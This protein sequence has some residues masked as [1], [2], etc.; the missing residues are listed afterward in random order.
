MR[1]SAIVPLAIAL[2]CGLI[3]AVGVSQVVLNSDSG[4]AE[5]K[6]VEIFV[7]VNDLD[8]GNKVT[9]DVVKLERWPAD[10]VPKGALNDLAKVEGKYARQRMFAGEPLMERKLMDSSN[11]IDDLIPEGYR[12]VTLSIKNDQGVA[13]LIEPGYR[14]DVNGFF[15]KSS[16]VPEVTTKTVL[17]NVRVFAVDGRTSRRDPDDDTP[18]RPAQVVSLLIRE[19]D[20]EVWT[21]AGEEGVLKLSIRNHSAGS[22]ENT[23]GPNPAGQA[24]MAWIK[25]TSRAAQQKED[26]EAAAAAASTAAALPV[27]LVEEKDEWEM[28]VL[29]PT[30]PRVYVWRPGSSVPEL[31]GAAAAAAA[32]PATDRA[33]LE[34][35]SS[36]FYEPEATPPTTPPTDSQQVVPG[37]TP[38]PA[39]DQRAGN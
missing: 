36:P 39:A 23:Q 21:W 31:V 38:E 6:T 30:G 17:S 20:Q 25:E 24:F 5:T 9:A 18:R 1:N 28:R 19:E 35:S 22:D 26:E 27:D 32:A 4:E 29:A 33:Y 7:T 15:E 12:A 37:P 3:A 13:Y 34:G 10:R 8:V 2:G 16:L 11:G 14:V